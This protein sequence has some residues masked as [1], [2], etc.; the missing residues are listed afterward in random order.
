VVAEPPLPEPVTVD[1]ENEQVRTNYRIAWRA[2]PRQAP[3]A[4]RAASSI[5]T[6]IM[7]ATGW[8]H[9]RLR[10]GE[11]DYVYSVYSRP[12]NGDTAGHYFIDTD[13]SPED[14][15]EVLSIIQGV[16]D[17]MKAGRFTDDELDLARKMIL[18]YDAL[19]KK[20]NENVVS[21]DALSILF[22]EGI[23]H[24]EKYYEAIRNV[25]REDVV[26]VANKIFGSNPLQVFVRPAGAPAGTR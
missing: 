14:E 4:E 13:I 3:D 9:A 22:G 17:D 18:S 11:N 25:K 23:D 6:A 24:A 16:I 8:L 21:G 5:M 15:G 26:Q 20:E 1:L 12:Y 2:L 7:G 10:E 19:R